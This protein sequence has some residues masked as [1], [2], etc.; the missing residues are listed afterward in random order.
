MCRDL[1]SIIYISMTQPYIRL[2]ANQNAHGT[3]PNLNCMPQTAYRR[4]CI[5]RCTGI[6]NTRYILVYSTQH[7]HEHA[8]IEYRSHTSHVRYTRSLKRKAQIG[9][10]IAEHSQ[11]RYRYVDC[12]ILFWTGGGRSGKSRLVPN[13]THFPGKVGKLERIFL[14]L[15]VG[16]N[17][18]SYGA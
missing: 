11:M 3:F 4:T 17:Y 2:W 8:H 14:Y 10:P 18:V 16:I 5:N 13:P 12:K 7:V 6:L 1:R 15:K 9:Q